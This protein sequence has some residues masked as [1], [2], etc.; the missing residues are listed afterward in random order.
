MTS[1]SDENKEPVTRT[2]IT[3]PKSFHKEI[4]QRALDEDITIN[5]L[6][7]KALRKYMKK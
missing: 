6:V 7:L 2:N 1:K 5:A 4:K 3:L